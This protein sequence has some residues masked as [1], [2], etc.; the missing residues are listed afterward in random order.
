MIRR[1]TLTEAMY[2]AIRLGATR[3]PPDIRRALQRALAE[4]TEP[5]ARKHLEISL[6]NADSSEKETAWSAP[7][8]ASRCFSSTP[9]LKRRSRAASTY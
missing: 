5:M 7:T 4:E 6:Q 9:E 8:P 2:Q 3:M 1:E